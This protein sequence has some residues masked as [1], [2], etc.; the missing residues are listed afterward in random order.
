MQESFSSLPNFNY[1]CSFR[2]RKK[3]RNAG[4][5]PEPVPSLKSLRNGLPKS[6]DRRTK[7]W[8]DY[9][10][11][12]TVGQPVCPPP[13]LRGGWVQLEEAGWRGTPSP[14]P[15][16]HEYLQRFWVSPPRARLPEASPARLPWGEPPGL[17]SVSWPGLWALSRLKARPSRF[18]LFKNLFFGQEARLDCSISEDAFVFVR[19]NVKHSDFSILLGYLFFVFFFFQISSCFQIPAGTLVRKGE[20]TPPPLY[21]CGS[22]KGMDLKNTIEAPIK[23][24]N[25]TLRI[26]SI[27][28]GSGLHEYLLP[29]YIPG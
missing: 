21:S 3:R 22:A 14:H 4:K 29:S 24:Q 2:K 8:G 1:L 16:I 5:H 23:R 27:S 18:S 12:R 17:K 11:P 19:G 7:M 25:I 20:R 6:S 28:L 13:P 26:I 15:H 10:C 9:L